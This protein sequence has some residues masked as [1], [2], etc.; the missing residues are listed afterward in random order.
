MQTELK[1]VLLIVRMSIAVNEKKNFLQR[2]R[3]IDPPL[4]NN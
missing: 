4:E 2:R 1:I 3:K